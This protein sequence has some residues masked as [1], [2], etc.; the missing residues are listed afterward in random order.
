MIIYPSINSYCPELIPSFIIINE[1]LCLPLVCISHNPLL[2]WPKASFPS[3][4]D[5]ASPSPRTITNPKWIWMKCPSPYY[6]HQLH[7][8]YIQPYAHNIKLNLISYSNAAPQTTYSQIILF[9]YTLAQ[10]DTT[11]M[12]NNQML[13][14]FYIFQNAM[15]FCISILFEIVSRN[16]EKTVPSPQSA[17]LRK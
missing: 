8:M 1:Y 7:L 4:I 12:S 14:I 5:R 10:N 11:Q 9:T 16:V 6:Y 3:V 13:L 2:P 15:F 17:S